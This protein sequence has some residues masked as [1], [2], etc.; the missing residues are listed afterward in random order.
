MQRVHLPAQAFVFLRKLRFQGFPALPVP[1]I[2]QQ[3]LLPF[4]HALLRPGDLRAEGCFLR[5]KA[6]GIL[7]QVFQ[8]N[9]HHRLPDI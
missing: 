8:L 6:G 2:G 3:K 9:L 5:L 4:L 7:P 1:G